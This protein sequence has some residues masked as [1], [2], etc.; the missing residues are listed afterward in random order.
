[1]ITNIK[2]LVTLVTSCADFEQAYKKV[3]STQ[4]SHIV[5]EWFYTEYSLKNKNKTQLQAFTNFYN[6]VK[7]GKYNE[8]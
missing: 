3:K 7:E 6:D 8:N 2:E 4:V 5:S 1:M